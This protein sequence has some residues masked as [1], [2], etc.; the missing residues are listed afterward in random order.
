MVI[1]VHPLNPSRMYIG[2]APVS[3]FRSDDA[4]ANV[5]GDAETPMPAQITMPF[6][7]RVMRL[8]AHPTDESVL[9]A[10]LEV[11][12]TMRS[13][14]GGETWEDTSADLLT[15]AE[16]PHLTNHLRTTVKAEGMLD[17]HA[18]EV[19]PK[20]P[21]SVFM[22]CRMGLFRSD[23]AARIGRIWRSA[24]SPRCAMDA[25]SGCRRSMPRCFTPASVRRRAAGTDRCIA[26]TT[27]A[28]TGRGSITRSRPMRR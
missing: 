15:M 22:A 4:G 28:G 23:D 11:D 14:D 26:V 7:C 13:L 6:P 20:A 3:I 10:T 12:G 27:A 24:A 9:Y 21:D 5:A 8:A 19:S 2:G 1:L 16:R 17:G 18:I 25:T